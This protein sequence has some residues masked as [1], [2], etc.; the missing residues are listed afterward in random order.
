MRTIKTVLLLAVALVA[1]CGSSDDV[2]VADADELL[3]ALVSGSP[4]ACSWPQVFGSK[5][6]TGVDGCRMRP[7]MRVRQV[8]EQDADADAENAFSGFLQIHEGSPLTS[9]DFVVIPRSFG[10]VPE[11]AVTD[12]STK[13]YDVLVKRWVPSVLASNATLTDVW[14]ADSTWRGVDQAIQ[15]FGA[16]T[17]GYVQQFQPVISQGSVWVPSRHGTLERMDLSTGSSTMIDPFAGTPF[18]GDDRLIVVGAPAVDPSTAHVYYTATDF[19][20]GVAGD[21]TDNGFGLDPKGSWLVDVDP[22]GATRIVE[23][24]TL[25]PTRLGI[26]G[27]DD[28]CERP[29]FVAGQVAT[30]PD[31]RPPLFRCGAQRPA[32]NAPVAISEDGTEIVAFSY[33]T[34]E[35][36]ASFLIHVSTSDLTPIRADDTRGHAHHGCGVRLVIDPND[37][38]NGCAVITANGSTNLGND[39]DYNGPVRFVGADIMDNAPA[40]APNGDVAIGNYDGGFSFGGGYDARGFG[41][42]FDRAGGFRALNTDFF[43][44]VTPSIVHDAGSPDGFRWLA[45]RNLYSDIDLGVASYDRSWGGARI[46]QVKPSTTSTAFDFLDAHVARDSDGSTYGVNGDGHVYK[47]DVTGRLIDAVVL[48]GDD[49]QPLSMETLSNYSARDAAGRLYVS[50]AGR[51]WVIE[52]SGSLSP[53]SSAYAQSPTAKKVLEAGRRAMRASLAH[54]SVPPPR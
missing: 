52:G 18:D 2:A 35:A 20:D 12:P 33:G 43:W 32:L 29:F 25:S 16:Y 54:R 22:S 8:I 42:S 17:N 21:A 11:A 31:S 39:P 36:S 46:G 41:M 44:E 3:Q 4:S 15:S 26:P 50:Y 28:R 34:D 40:I 7:G 45:D 48:P 14:H 13:R 53:V 47:F 49:G 1:G 19:P 9:G 27:P 24:S 10:F 37:D 23:W 6:H 51:V 5:T 30:G 38:A